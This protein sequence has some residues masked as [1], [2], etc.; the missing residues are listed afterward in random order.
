MFVKINILNFKF[1]IVSFGNLCAALDS[2]ANFI[3][4]YQYLPS[5]T[6]VSSW[7]SSIVKGYNKLNFI[8]P[9]KIPKNSMLIMRLYGGASVLLDL[10]QNFI[11]TDYQ[12]LGVSLK[13]LN[14]L[15]NLRFDL[16][17]LISTKY[18]FSYFTFVYQYQDPNSYHVQL[19]FKNITKDSLSRLV[20]ITNGILI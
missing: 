20:N 6:V 10:N 5:Y 7:N 19:N 3:A 18:Y 1:K 9:Q 4:S 15:R 13:R 17:C 16:N 2:C 12:I 14:G 11:Y 8:V